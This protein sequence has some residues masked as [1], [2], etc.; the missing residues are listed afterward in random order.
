VSAAAIDLLAHSA[1]TVSRGRKIVVDARTGR[2]TPWH[3]RCTLYPDVPSFLAAT[4]DWLERDPVVNNIVATNMLMR[5]GGPLQGEDDPMLI[6]VA[7][8][9]GTV[10]GAAVRTP[11]RS[12]LLPHI[13]AAVALTIADFV[14]R[15][16]AAGVFAAELPG[17]VGPVAAA[18][19]F[20]VRW[21]ELTGAAGRVEMR[22][23]AFRLD[24]VQPPAG[25][26]GRFRLAAAADLDLCFGWMVDFQSEA[27]PQQPKVHRERIADTIAD[28]RMG[29][30]EDAG[31]SVSMVG[32]TIP[33]A[34]VIRIG[35]VYTPPEL[36]R[37]GYGSACTAEMSRR[38]LESGATACTLTTDLANPTSNA[39]Y[40][41]IGYYPVADGV[42]IL[43]DRP[44]S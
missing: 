37:H 17:V 12:L 24:R 23:R 13:P 28:G 6:T 44:V 38:A 31:R 30:W 29:L 39:I 7:A 27:L 8:P 9:D 32:R 5:V 2:E 3:M 11:P 22:Q 1:G 14:A 4:R 35:P 42:S 20:A 36:R 16:R 10:V 26:A 41:R 33:A 43:F 21:S 18:E 40:R 19:P 34:G 25:V 15:M